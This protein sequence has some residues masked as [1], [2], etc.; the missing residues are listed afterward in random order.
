MVRAGRT[1]LG[2]IRQD[3]DQSFNAR[4]TLKASHETSVQIALDFAGAILDQ[5]YSP[6]RP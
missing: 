6:I 5:R 3:I 4:F 1:L 2:Q